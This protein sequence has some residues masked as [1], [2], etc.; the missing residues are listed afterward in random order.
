LVVLRGNSGSGKTSVAMGLRTRL[1]RGLALVQQDVLRRL[2]LKERDVPRGANIGLIS[3]TTRYA[4]DHGYDVI[5][6]G[7]MRAERYAD[8]L[9]ALAA[10]HR[11]P[12]VFYYYDVSFTETVRRHG[13]R[14]Q[15]SEFGVEDMCQ[16]YRDRDLLPFTEER[17]LTEAASLPDTVDRILC[18]VFP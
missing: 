12:T 3:M 10:D 6:E 13:T 4:L 15:A 9:A 18:E 14:P 1:G 16:W 11:G 17:I 8:M 7:I 2:V 5:L